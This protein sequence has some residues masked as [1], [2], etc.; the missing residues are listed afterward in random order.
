MKKFIFGFIIL[1]VFTLSACGGGNKNEIIFWHMSPVGSKSFSGMQ[2][3]ISD[4]N[5][6]QDKYHVKGIG[7]SF[8]DYWD[9]LNI[10]VASRTAPDIG[11]QTLDNSVLRASEGVIYNLSD[12]IDADKEAGL[13]EIDLTQFYQNQLDFTKYEGDL[14]S[15]PFTATTRV[16]YYNKDLF[17]AAGLTEEDVPTT[18]SELYTVAKKLDVVENGEIKQLGFD[19]TYGQGTYHGYLWQN[20]LDFFDENLN[21]TLNT[22]KHVEVLEWMLNFNKEYSRSQ[23]N[24]FGEANA[25][26]GIDPFAGGKVAMIVGVD[27]LY[28]TMRTAGSKIN[29]GVTSIPIP[30]KNGVRVNW[31]SGFSLELFNNGKGD[32][33]K[34]KVSWEFMKYLMSEEIQIRLANVNGWLMGHKGAMTK[35]AEGNDILTALIEEVE[36][37]VDKVYVPYAPSWHAGDWQKFY[38]K[39]KE[40]TLTPAETISQAR[41]F[42]IHKQEDYNYKNN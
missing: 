9:K 24:S 11:L 33:E 22:D 16:L 35:V 2:A 7:F 39:V 10:A 21:P 31:G 23:L 4:F 37:A 12:F 29:Y 6:S 28:Q 19:P 38:D 18:W 17:E 30:D 14:Y 3:I 36:Y 20:G 5:D 27:G 15:M 40:G 13:E 26:L 32:T 25:L 41:E 8:W 1:S 34:A 42:Y